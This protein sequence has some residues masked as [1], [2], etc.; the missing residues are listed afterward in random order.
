MAHVLTAGFV[1]IRKAGKL[2]P[3]RNGESVLRVAYDMEY[4][5]NELE[6]SKYVFS[7]QYSQPPCVVIVDDLMATGGTAI[8]AS[9]LIRDAGV[10]VH[11]VAVVIELTSAPLKG[12]Q[13]LKEETGLDLFSLLQI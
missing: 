3:G 2:P 6:M 11:E 7:N 8:A 12:K 1:M 13:C 10:N 4:G 5:H 9:R